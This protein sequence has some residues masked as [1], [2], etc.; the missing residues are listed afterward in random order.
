MSIVIKIKITLLNILFA[1]GF[2][3]AQTPTV[4]LQELGENYDVGYTLFSPE[5][6]EFVYLI[7]S[8][9][10]VLNQWEFDDRPNRTAY[11]L[12]NGDVVRAG[13]KSLAIRDWDNNLKWSVSTSELGQHHDIEPLPN[14]NILIIAYDKY[15]KSQIV[16]QG[17]I[18]SFEADSI[19]LDKIIEIKPIGTSE[20]QVVWEWKLF[21]HLIQDLYPEKPNYGSVSEN[22]HRFNINFNQ[23]NNFSHINSIDYNV[24]LDQVLLSARNLSEIFIIDHSTTL[25]EA[26]EFTGGNFD[27]GGDILWRYGNLN[28]LGNGPFDSTD[29]YRQHDASWVENGFEDDEAISVFNN[30]PGSFSKLC[31][32]R[33]VIESNS[34]KKTTNQFE[35]TSATLCWEGEIAGSQMIEDRKAGVKNL[36]NGHFLVCETSKGRITEIDK[37]GNIYWS[38]VNPHGEEK[39]DQG[40]NNIE[41]NIIFRAD[42][43]PLNYLSNLERELPS[44]LSLIENNN[45]L[46]ENCRYEI[47]PVIAKQN[48]VQVINPVRNGVLLLKKGA[49]QI[50]ELR[51]YS[52]TGKL[53]MKVVQPSERIILDDLNAGVYHLYLRTGSTI[54]YEKILLQ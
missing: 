47:L 30:N 26:S 16:G 38:Y 39:F 28:I 42:R 4:G 10:F 8:C 54:E 22:L 9:G 35:P 48:D 31:L 6:N 17:M 1:F 5:N 19:I 24:E 32:V 50:Q 3:N 23:I 21:D 15:S 40:S 18:E 27:R 13:K 49:N 51:I 44:G 33:P 29:L 7:E 52:N 14:G 53:L 37:Q 2:S 41:T 34:Y 43:Y 11:L 46:S 45:R 20:F 12:E 25:E 36:R